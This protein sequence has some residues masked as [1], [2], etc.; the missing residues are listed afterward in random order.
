MKQNIIKILLS[1]TLILFLTGPLPLRAE[2]DTSLKSYLLSQNLKQNEE[3][4]IEEFTIQGDLF[5]SEPEKKSL[6]K[7]IFLS[8]LMPGGGE[9]YVGSK[10]RARIF[11]GLRL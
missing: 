6:S 5:P 8:L 10:T 11:L 2:D 9:F 7:A 3:P 1:L 4:E